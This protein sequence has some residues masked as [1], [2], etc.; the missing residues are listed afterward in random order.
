VAPGIHER[1][2]PLNTSPVKPLEPFAGPE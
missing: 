1:V 2:K